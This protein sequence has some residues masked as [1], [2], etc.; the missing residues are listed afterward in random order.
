MVG[1]ASSGAVD[2]CTASCVVSIYVRLLHM[3]L[4]SDCSLKQ[5]V[6]Y[7]RWQSTRTCRVQPW[8]WC[9]Q[10]TSAGWRM[11]SALTTS[12]L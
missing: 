10:L 4:P 8:R 9:R 11:S 6:L 2:A 12:P 5:H 7:C 1:T 3:M